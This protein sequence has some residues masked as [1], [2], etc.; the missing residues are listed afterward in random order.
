MGVDAVDF[1]TLDPSFLFTLD[2]FSDAVIAD[3]FKIFD[4]TH[5]IFFAVPFI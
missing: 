4:H 5:S 1:V 3:V 2:K